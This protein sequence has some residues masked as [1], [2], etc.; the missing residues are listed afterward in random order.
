MKLIEAKAKVSAYDN[1]LSK[2]DFSHLPTFQK[3]L[4]DNGVKVHRVDHA[5]MNSKNVTATVSHEHAEKA[6]ALAK[7]HT[8]NNPGFHFGVATA[9]TLK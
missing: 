4:E 7:E 9:D 6:A 3:H 1:W 5:F 2:Q 8:K